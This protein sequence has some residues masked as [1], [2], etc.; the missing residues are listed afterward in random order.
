MILS[1]R[2]LLRMSRYLFLAIL[3]L[4]LIAC[5]D[6]NRALKTGDRN[7]KLKYADEYFEKDDYMK[8]LPLYEE[9]IPLFR[10][11]TQSEHVYYRYAYCHYGIEDYYLASYYFRTF[12]KTYPTGQYAEEA[13]FLSAL[14]HYKNSPRW[15]L[16]QTDTKRAIDEMQIFMNRYPHSPK[17]DTCNVLIDELR[18]K[19]EVKQYKTAVQYYKTRKY[20]AAVIALEN[21]LREY[22][23]SEYREDIM[24][25]QLKANFDLATHS[26]EHKKKERLKNTIG[27]Y[28]KFV[29]RYASSKKINEAESIYNECIKLLESYSTN[30]TEK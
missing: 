6:Y 13:S 10:G 2:D 20:R 7:Y 4:I 15:S 16:D 19:L 27:S 25:Y 24:Y 17:K 22:P 18:Y 23:N 28:H 9:C 5:S 30:T 29:D 21:V 11:L 3:P 8:A 1:L 12:A 14:C 26:V